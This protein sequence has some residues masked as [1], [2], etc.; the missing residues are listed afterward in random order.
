MDVSIHQP[1]YLPW[2]PYFRK[3]E[4]CDLFIFLDSVDFTK[5]GLQNRNQ[6]RTEQG[7]QW[8]TVPVRQRLG[9]KIN[10]VAID[11]STQWG[12]K[13]W[14]RLQ[15]SYSNAA[16]FSTYKNQ[17]SNLLTQE[18]FDLSRLNVY[19]IELM[20]N[21]LE[22]DTPTLK[23]SQLKSTGRSS[24]LI[25]NLCK[26]VGASR[27]IS[28][29][30]GKQ[31]LELAKFEKEGIEVIFLDPIAPETYPQ[32][33]PQVEFYNDLSAIDILFNCGANWRSYLPEGGKLH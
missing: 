11:T 1:Q 28:G 3:I 17:F 21:L 30:G 12:R 20:L 22:I 14:E 16:S 5:N 6:I 23:S 15:H 2:T 13:H 24:D 32:P 10:E 27:Y 9:Q 33:F 29:S 26:E 25:V 4:Q 19:S 31:Y 18:W 7:R 8:L